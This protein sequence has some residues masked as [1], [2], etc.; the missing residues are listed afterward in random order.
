MS[1]HVIE[2]DPAETFASLRDRLLRAGQGR[3]VLVPSAR[4]D[5]LRRGVNLVLLRRLVVREHLEVGLITTDRSLSA[6]ARALGVPTFRNLVLA[7]HYQPGWWRARRQRE[8]VGFAPGEASAGLP[9]R[10]VRPGTVLAAT[11][12]ILIF[13]ALSVGI[14]LILLVP[15]ATITLR[16]ATWPLQVIYEL[17]ADRSLTEASTGA[18]PAGEIRIAQN[19]DA[20]GPATGDPAADRRRMRAQALQGLSSSAPALLPAHVSEGS[21]L[22][23]GSAQVEVT[24]ETFE[25]VGNG[26]YRLSLQAELIGLTVAR[27]DIVQAAQKEMTPLL[28]SAFAIDPATIVLALEA[29]PGRTDSFQVTARAE[30][31]AQLDA[32]SLRQAIKGRRVPIVAGYLDQLPLAEPPELDIVPAWWNRW[33]Q[34]VPLLTDRIQVE[35]LP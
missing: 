3:V 2:L 19:W 33:F 31:R 32:F 21:S 20:E 25:P 14:G 22:A 13:I 1:L 5:F 30:G 17:T 7:E 9:E 16:P 6:Q 12:G 35:I 4:S 28:P 11:L 8:R 18:I 15:R 24:A 27:E 26:R 29:L 34:R 23:P 10:E